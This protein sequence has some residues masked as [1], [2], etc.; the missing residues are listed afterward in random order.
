[1]LHI[2]QDKPFFPKTSDRLGFPALV[3]HP[4]NQHLD[5]EHKR[6]FFGLFQSAAPTDFLQ[7][8]EKDHRSKQKRR[9]RIRRRSLLNFN[10]VNLQR[11]LD[12]ESPRFQ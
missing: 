6:E 9:P 4:L 7:H 1:L 3:S 2:Y 11:R 12:L 5:R 8:T 10:L